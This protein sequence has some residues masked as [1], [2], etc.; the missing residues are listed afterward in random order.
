MSLNLPKSVESKVFGLQSSTSQ[1]VSELQALA[2]E[3]PTNEWFRQIVSDGTAKQFEMEHNDR[4]LEVARP[5]L[6]AF[7][8]AR[9]FLEM[10]VRYGKEMEVA[11]RVVPSGW[12]ALLYLYELR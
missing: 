10:A 1:I 2:P 4:W 6:E 12:A 5:I 8:H 9:Y 7:F 3:R 11:P